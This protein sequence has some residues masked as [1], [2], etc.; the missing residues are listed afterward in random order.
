MT[1][2]TRPKRHHID[3]RAAAIALND[4]GSADQLLCTQA[5]A[6]WIGVSVQFLEIGR[7]KGYGPKFKKISPTCVRYMR[8]DVL[9]WLMARTHSIT[10]EYG[11]R[12][13]KSA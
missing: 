2:P 13:N 8:A 6:D 11:G 9:A 4:T 7:C 12:R 3:K 1:T 5:L 10:S